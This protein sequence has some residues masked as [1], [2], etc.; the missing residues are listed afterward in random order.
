MIEGFRHKGLRQL[1][2]D[3]NARGVNPDHVTKLKVILTVMNTAHDIADLD[4][5]TFRLHPLTGNLKGFCPSRC[6]Q[7]GG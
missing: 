2:E 1:L 5:A 7:I 6:A 3:D 4:V